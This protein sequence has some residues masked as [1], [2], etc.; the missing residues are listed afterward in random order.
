VCRPQCVYTLLVGDDGLRD[1]VMELL[2][3]FRLWGGGEN[4]PL[5]DV[6]PLAPDCS[7]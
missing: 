1:D 5:V 2:E 6:D 3:L 7:E 4:G